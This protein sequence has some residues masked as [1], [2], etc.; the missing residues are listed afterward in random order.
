MLI[1]E[2]MEKEKLQYLDFLQGNI[3]RMSQCSFQ[4]KGLAMVIV[5]A[6]LAIYAASLS[7]MNSNGNVTFII[8]AIIPTVIFWVLDSYYLSKEKDYRHIYEIVAGL[9]SPDIKIDIFCLD[10]KVLGEKQTKVVKSII[11]VTEAG[12][13]GTVILFLIVLG[14]IVRF[15]L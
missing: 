12:L 14:I 15:V 9:R 4:M 3:A 11:S 1:G 2:G 8:I 6:L 5:A 13:Y 10:T 7:G